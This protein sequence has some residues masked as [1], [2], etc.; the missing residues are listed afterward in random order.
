MPGA[1]RRYHTFGHPEAEPLLQALIADL[2]GFEI[3]EEIGSGFWTG[4]DHTAFMKRGVCAMS[5][6]GDLGPGVKYYHSSG[7]TYEEVDRRGTNQAAAVFARGGATI[8]SSWPKKKAGSS[9]RLWFKRAKWDP[10][11]YRFESIADRCK[12]PLGCG[13]GFPAGLLAVEKEVRQAGKPVPHT[14]SAS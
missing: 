6:S 9:I 4:S 1:P 14:F 2:K 8:P 11:L 3:S 7:D 12:S 5:L 10:R 13:T